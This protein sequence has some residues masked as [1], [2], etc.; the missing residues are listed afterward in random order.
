MKKKATV[1]DIPLELQEVEVPRISRQSL[2]EGDKVVN[3]MRRPSLPQE[4]SMSRP[5]AYSR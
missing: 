2:H 3:P 1:L 4:M 5:E